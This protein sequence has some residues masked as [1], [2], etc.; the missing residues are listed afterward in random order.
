MNSLEQLLEFIGQL[1]E[2][3]IHFDLKCVRDAIMVTVRSPGTYY[4]IEFFADGHIEVETL[5]QSTGV[6]SVTLKEI[7]SRV[8]ED[9]NGEL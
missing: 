4:E 9:L 1:R 7:T 6:S 2:Y 3:R 8:I 5:G